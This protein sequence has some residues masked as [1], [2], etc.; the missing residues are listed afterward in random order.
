[1]TGN[2]LNTQLGFRMEDTAES[3]FTKQ[4]KFDAINNA[5][6]QVVALVDNHYLPELERR[7]NGSISTST[8]GSR[9]VGYSTLWSAETHI[10]MRHN[11]VAI[12][13]TS[14]GSHNKFFTI[15][16]AEDAKITDN[17]YLSGTTANPVAWFFDERIY[18]QPDT[19][20]DIQVWYI[21]VPA[22]YVYSSPSSTDD[23]CELNAVLEPV[24]LDL[25]EAELWRSDGN[26]NRASG[27]LQNAMTVIQVLNGRLNADTTEKGIN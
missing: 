19:I 23:E 18:I 10:P 7:V 4:Q 11:I 12:K 24:V 22:E 17:A 27:A 1:M 2:E 9:Y 14:G 16:N 13:D 25:A 20:S 15:I 21:R 26:L 5:I 3:I 6:K 8:D